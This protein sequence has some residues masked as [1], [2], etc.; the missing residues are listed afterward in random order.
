MKQ[1]ILII[2]FS[3]LLL[4]CHAQDKIN[5]IFSNKILH[6]ASYA[7]Y[8]A[9]ASTGELLSESPQLSLVPASTMKIVTTAA[10]LEIL[11]P[12]F[13]F[14]TA[15][16]YTG[17]VSAK[18]GILAGDLI[19]RGGCDPTFYS[20]CFK[21]HYRGTFENWVDSIKKAGIKKIKGNLVVDVSAMDDSTI[22][23][24][25]IWED[26]GNYYGTGVSGMS[27]EDN[28]YEIH[29]RSPAQAGKPTDVVYKEPEI[30]G[31]NLENQV[32]SSNVETDSAFV[33]GAPHSYQQVV[34][35]A[36]PKNQSNFIVRAATPDPAFTAAVEFRKILLR[37][38]I[39]IEGKTIKRKQYKS[40]H[41]TALAVKYSPKLGEIIVPLNHRSI[42]LFAEHLLRELGRAKK[43]DPSL[44]S[45]TQALSEFWQS[46][47]IYLDGFF[48]SD[49]SGL[50][51][52]NNICPRTLVE[53]LDY[54][55][56][57]N[58][59]DYFYNSLP[60]AGE[61]GTLR[62]SF[63]GSPLENNLRA[64]T[65]TINRVKSLA[66]F[67]TNSNGRKVIFAV[68]VNNFS[69]PVTGVKMVF[70]QFLKELF[71]TLP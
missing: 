60:I 19:I 37:R 6:T 26:I 70:D 61:S 30:E 32:V 22:P 66:G 8:V 23:G 9:D 53:I 44:K 34:K 3:G 16:A 62:N 29:F 20:E 55:N 56:K 7:Y 48:P 57:S 5:N 58:Y 18:A 28:S 2:F 25:W 11:G 10:A 64:K 43:G 33:Y 46:K 40:E 51:H 4:F 21:D 15:I 27:Y 67:F 59:K 1:S 52:S 45:S 50:S 54:I 68:I 39:V 42:N 71:Y 17:T 31:L 24:D 47:G 63:H 12:D 14:R 36:I 69:G 13:R 38:G 41:I 35:G 65:G 49:G